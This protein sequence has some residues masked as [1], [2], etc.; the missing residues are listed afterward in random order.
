MLALQQLL[1]KDHKK[2]ID[3]LFQFGRLKL[4]FKAAE[5]ESLKRTDGCSASNSNSVAATKNKHFRLP[6]HP[7]M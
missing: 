3:D 5:R 4:T 1:M 2:P 7:Q 6:R